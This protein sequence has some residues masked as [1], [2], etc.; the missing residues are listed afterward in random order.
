MSLLLLVR[1]ERQVGAILGVNVVY[2]DCHI[3]LTSSVTP[4]FLC[5]FTLI[6]RFINSMPGKFQHILISGTITAELP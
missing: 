5:D 4:T 3:F 6:L 2:C 1:N